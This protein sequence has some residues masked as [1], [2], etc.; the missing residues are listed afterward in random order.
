MK[1][2]VSVVIATYNRK[3]LLEKT[4]QSLVNQSYPKEKYE[5]LV[6]DDGSSDGTGKMVEET[7]EKMDCELRYF[8]Q[9]NR[10]PAT[11]RNLG[12][13]NA[14]GGIIA[15]IDDDC[16]ADRAWLE[17][18]INAFK[19]NGNILGVEGRTKTIP[20]KVTPFT[21]QVDNKGGGYM[22]CNMAYRK[23]ILDKVGG[24]DINY[25]FQFDEDE[26]LAWN[27]LRYGKIHFETKAIVI[28]PP[29]PISTIDLLKKVRHLESDFRLHHKFPDF[30]GK[31]KFK[32]PLWCFIYYYTYFVFLREVIGKRN[33]IRTDPKLFFKYFLVLVLQRVYLFLLIPLWYIRHLRTNYDE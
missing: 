31:Y 26:D 7:K 32:H 23:D 1:F 4:L 28:H 11:A 19:L 27:V 25:P 15:F 21:K 33:L 8:K 10:G 22:T 29:R 13:N 24:F 17:E 30:Y 14:K 6:V 9:K 3:S 2:D 18:I 5:I 20:E 12:I 16:I